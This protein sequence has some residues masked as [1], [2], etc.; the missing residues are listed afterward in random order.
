MEINKKVKVTKPKSPYDYF[1]IADQYKYRYVDYEIL[2][3]ALEKAIPEENLRDYLTKPKKKYN[4][5]VV[6]PRESWREWMLRNLEFKDPPLVER[7]ELPEELQPQNRRFAGLHHFI[8]K[9]TISPLS[10]RPSLQPRI[11]EETM[12]DFKLHEMKSM[13]SE[14]IEVR[15][16]S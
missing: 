5:P 7:N 16:A 12:S 11:P 4:D 15:S 6:D 8:T 10:Q 14:Q 9:M 3:D 1:H 2:V 13:G